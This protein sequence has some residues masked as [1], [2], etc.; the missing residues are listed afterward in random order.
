MKRIA[1]FVLA[2]LLAFAASAQVT[3]NPSV[4]GEPAPQR[5]V[6]I[7]GGTISG[8]T[9]SAS[10]ITDTGLAATRVPFATTGGLLTD[11][12]AFTFTSGTG[13]LAAPLLNGGGG[14]FTGA[15]LNTG[16]AAFLAIKSSTSTNV[17]G[18][19]TSFPLVFGTANFNQSGSYNTGTGVFTAP[20]TG[21]YRFHLVVLVQQFLVTHTPTLTF[22]IAGTSAFT[23]NSYGTAL[24]AGDRSLEIHVLAKMTAGDTATPSLFIVGGTKTVD[25]YGDASGNSYFSGELVF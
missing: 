1:A 8:V 10:S 3:T 21:Y 14:N 22:T 20:T 12:A 2:A 19:G 16:K 24:F 7:T 18:D 23:F 5:A 25:V 17:T 9:L 4:T 6:A 11:S 13:A 15:V